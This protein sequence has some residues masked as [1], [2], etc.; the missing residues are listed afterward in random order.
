[1]AFNRRYPICYTKNG[2][3]TTMRNLERNKRNLVALNY[4]GLTN[5]VDSEGNLTGEK[6][7]IYSS[8]L[9]FKAHISSAKGTTQIENFGVNAD[10][11]KTIIIT[12]REFDRLGLDENSVFFIDKLP[13]YD[14]HN[15]PLY[16][17]R[18]KRI[19]QTLN[20]VAIALLKVRD[21][22]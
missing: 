6:T 17:Y 19:A 3:N 4:V 8:E 5:D 10:Y 9:I 21:N 18:V 11:D 7:I 22:G 13:Q 16:D 2:R 20:E 1:M 15:N 14:S 12:K